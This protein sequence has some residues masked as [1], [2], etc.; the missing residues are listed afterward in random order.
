M[1]VCMW[2]LGLAGASSVTGCFLFMSIARMENRLIIDTGTLTIKV[3]ENMLLP[4]NCSQVIYIEKRGK[5]IDEQLLYLYLYL[6]GL[7]L[8]VVLA[9]TL[10]SLADKGFVSY[11]NS[12]RVTVCA[13]LLLVIPEGILVGWPFAIGFTLLTS[14][15][16]YYIC[17]GTEKIVKLQRMKDE[18]KVR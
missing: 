10:G 4:R 18:K 17:W 1:S 7:F 9:S 15:I 16:V 2:T 14:P 3:R 12:R 5:N 13:Y 11:R 8:F 6:L